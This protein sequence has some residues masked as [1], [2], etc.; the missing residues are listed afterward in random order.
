MVFEYAEHDFL[1][2]ALLRGG[3]I[4]IKLN[5]DL[6]NYTLPFAYGTKTYSWSHCQVTVMAIN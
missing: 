3:G 2:S 4:R 1:V 6:A 5:S